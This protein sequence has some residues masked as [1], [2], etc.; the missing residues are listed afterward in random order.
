MILASVTGALL[1]ASPMV[2]S[3]STPKTTSRTTTTASKD[4]CKNLK[5]QALK[6]C[7]AKAAAAKKGA[8][9]K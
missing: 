8:K 3:A 6:D 5:G 1:L 2:A 4:T 9:A 7:K